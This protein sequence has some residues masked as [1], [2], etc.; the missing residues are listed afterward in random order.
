MLIPTKGIVFKSI[1]YAESTLICKIY[2]QHLGLRTYI[3]PGA[4]RSKARNQ[5][6]FLQPLSL[7]EFVAYEHPHKNMHHL[8]DL[9]ADVV[10]SSIPFDVVKSG[11]ALFFAEIF[12]KCIHEE[13]ENEALFRFLHQSI[14]YLDTTSATK[15]SL[16]PVQVLATLSRHLGFFPQMNFSAQ[17]PFFDLVEACF[18]PQSSKHCADI[19][20]GQLLYDYVEKK[21]PP[22]S[23]KEKQALL[24]LWINYYQHQIEGFGEVH[25][26]AILRSVF[27]S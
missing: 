17:T 8:R 4:R 11:L 21:I 24:N 3:V 5:A 6:A 27:Y 14:E 20:T 22:A 25:A 2:T 10:F 12:T 18:L 16:L 9:K 19:H 7:V 26:L 23:L 1:K 15:L 13:T